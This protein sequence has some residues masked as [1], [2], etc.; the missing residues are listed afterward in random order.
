MPL[1]KGHIMHPQ[2]RKYITHRN[3]A[4]KLL[5]TYAENWVKFGHPVFEICSRT[6]RYADR[7][8]H[9]LYTGDKVTTIGLHE[10][11]RA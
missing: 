7:K 9:T 8:L 1:P 3:A 5:A 4:C 6:V 2:N 10:P 11:I